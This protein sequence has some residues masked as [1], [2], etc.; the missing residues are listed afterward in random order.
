MVEEWHQHELFTSSLLSKE[1]TTDVNIF[2]DDVIIQNNAR[3]LKKLLLTYLV[4]CSASPFGFHELVSSKSYGSLKMVYKFSIFA[5]GNCGFGHIYWRNL[6]FMCSVY[7]ICL[8]LIIMTLTLKQ[9][10]VLT[11]CISINNFEHVLF[12]TYKLRSV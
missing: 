10:C 4:R 1:E 5:L 8:K 2:I 3:K 11:S 7:W 12:L 6:H 9:F